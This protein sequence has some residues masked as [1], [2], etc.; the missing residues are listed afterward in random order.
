MGSAVSPQRPRPDVWWPRHCQFGRIVEQECAPFQFALFTRA[1]TDC[2]GHAIRAMTY[3]NSRATVLSV[4]G[5]GAYD[6]V[7]RSS[8]LGKLLEVPRSSSDPIRQMESRVIP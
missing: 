8:M 6:H 2:V 4:D 3:L 7:L 5:I 1:G